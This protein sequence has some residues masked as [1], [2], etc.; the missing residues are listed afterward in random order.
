M[1]NILAVLIPTSVPSLPVSN[2]PYSQFREFSEFNFAF[3]T[4]LAECFKVRNWSAINPL[5]AAAIA[6]MLPFAILAH[7]QGPGSAAGE[8]NIALHPEALD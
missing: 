5:V 6:A 1:A 8:K 4:R 2:E 3:K 7:A